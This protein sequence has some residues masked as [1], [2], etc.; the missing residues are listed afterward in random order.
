VNPPGRPW[1]HEA[2]SP[3]DVAGRRPA[4]RGP[5]AASADANLGRSR[6]R[7]AVVKGGQ[8]TF[9]DCSSVSPGSN[10]RPFDEP[11]PRYSRFPCSHSAL[12]DRAPRLG[13]VESTSAG[14]ERLANIWKR[15]LNSDSFAS[16]GT[17]TLSAMSA[18]WRI[19]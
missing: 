4:G 7:G 16:S 9:S 8:L 19:E 1:V 13:F 10:D 6:G 14:Q 18:T 17:I 11:H 12:V 15:A 2:R 5:P 3:A